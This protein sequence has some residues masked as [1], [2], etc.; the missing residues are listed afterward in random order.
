VGAQEVHD[1]RDFADLGIVSVMKVSIGERASGILAID[2]WGVE[3]GLVVGRLVFGFKEATRRRAGF[4]RRL[5]KARDLIAIDDVDVT[6]HNINI[7]HG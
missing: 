2:W 3:L 7:A 1:A 6:V 5:A 4:S